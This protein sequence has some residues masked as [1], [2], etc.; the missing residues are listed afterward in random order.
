[1]IGHIIFLF[2][3]FIALLFMGFGLIIT[4][5][6][7]IIFATQMSK[8]KILKQQTQI[9]EDAQKPDSDEPAKDDTVQ[10]DNTNEQATKVSF[11]GSKFLI[12]ILV[13]IAIIII[14][15]YMQ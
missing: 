9:M 10:P 6:L 5:P 7:H 2:L 14:F 1:M 8:N 11:S 3:H 13:L 4:I 12:L 15:N